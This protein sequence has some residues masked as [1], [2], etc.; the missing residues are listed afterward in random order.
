MRNKCRYCNRPLCRGECRRQQGPGRQNTFVEQLAVGAAVA[1]AGIA[2]NEGINWIRQE[3]RGRTQRSEVRERRSG[4]ERQRPDDEAEQRRKR[5]QELERQ[6]LVEES[7]KRKQAAEMQPNQQCNPSAPSNNTTDTDTG[8]ECIICLDESRKY[9]LL[10][11]GHFCLCENC[12]ARVPNN[13]CPVCRN[14]IQ[15]ILRIYN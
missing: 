11:C 9:A 2:I 3:V 15:D 7:Q 12:V 4:A 10:P 8:M 14:E 13:K 6:R 5:N 1:L